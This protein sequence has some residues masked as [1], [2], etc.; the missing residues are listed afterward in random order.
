MNNPS[1]AAYTAKVSNVSGSGTAITAIRAFAPE[2][3]LVSPN[4]IVAPISCSISLLPPGIG[5]KGFFAKSA[6]KTDW[7]GWYLDELVSRLR[8]E[9]A[10]RLT[11]VEYH[12]WFI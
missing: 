8:R 1:P 3:T 5:C 2:A 6:D 10:G 11:T 4:N 9:P 12:G 7:Y